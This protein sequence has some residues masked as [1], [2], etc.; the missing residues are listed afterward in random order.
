MLTVGGNISTILHPV[1]LRRSGR[2]L[3]DWKCFARKQLS[4]PRANEPNL[5]NFQIQTQTQ[6]QTQIQ[7]QIQTQIC[8]GNKQLQSGSTLWCRPLNPT[9]KN[10]LSTNKNK[11]TSQ[12]ETAKQQSYLCP[13]LR[14]ANPTCKF[15]FQ[16]N[17][18]HPQNLLN[19]FP[20]FYVS[21]SS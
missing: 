20:D 10:Q 16:Q 19:Q 13:A 2:R 8:I 5:Q 3:K 21:N 14:S 11:N 18:H 7:I 6:T 17:I 4:A 9:C 15:H 12:R 1:H